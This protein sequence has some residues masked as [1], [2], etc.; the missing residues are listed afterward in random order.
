MDI[1]SPTTHNFTK[2]ETTSGLVYVGMDGNALHSVRSWG[3][4]S[5]AANP[6]FEFDTINLKMYGVFNGTATPDP[7]Q[8]NIEVVTALPGSPDANT[9]YFVV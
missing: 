9:L 3:V 4:F 1:S 2:V 7:V 8:S 5:S 6:A